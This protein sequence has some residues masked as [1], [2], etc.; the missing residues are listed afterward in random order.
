MMLPPLTFKTNVVAMA[1]TYMYV[2]YLAVAKED[3]SLNVTTESV[4]S[5]Y[6]PFNKPYLHLLYAG[7]P[8]STREAPSYRG[9]YLMG[10]ID[11]IQVVTYSSWDYGT[12]R[13]TP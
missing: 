6:T 13:P 11:W 5:S 12:D 7:N 9:R 2:T 1:H 10:V 3:S 8:S 4:T